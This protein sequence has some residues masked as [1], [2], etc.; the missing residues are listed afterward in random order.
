M[1][2][3]GIPMTI[4]EPIHIVEC[5]P[6]WPAMF[7]MERE[8]LCRR[9]GLSEADIQHIGS[10]EVPGLVAKPIID[11]MLGLNVYPPP[12]ALTLEIERL[13]YESLGEAGVP[14]RLHFR[15]RVPQAFN[16]HVVRRADKLWVSNLALRDY[17]RTHPSAQRRYAETKRQAL[18]SGQ[19]TLLSYSEAKARV[20]N[21]IL[22]QALEWNRAS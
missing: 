10:T 20:I 22:A 6:R 7:T 11:L 2:L 12:A 3:A 18:A 17:L 1:T 15:R 5:D 4:D 21:E 8:R 9:L 13:G 14:E 19:N 16:L